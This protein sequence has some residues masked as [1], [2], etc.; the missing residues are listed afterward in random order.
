MAAPEPGEPTWYRPAHVA[1]HWGAANPGRSHP[2]PTGF[3]TSWSPV[4]RSVHDAL[5]TF[6]ISL[7]LTIEV[8]A[9]AQALLTMQ[10]GARA[11]LVRIAARLG[12][13]PSGSGGA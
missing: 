13:A 2:A 1:D 3:P 6:F 7:E 5:R 11:E 4:N 8:F 12:V 9:T 10:T